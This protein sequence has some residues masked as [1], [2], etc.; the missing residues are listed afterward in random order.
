MFKCL[1]GVCPYGVI[2]S[3]DIDF[4]CLINIIKLNSYQNSK[5]YTVILFYIFNFK[6]IIMKLLEVDKGHLPRKSRYKQ[7]V[8]VLKDHRD[9]HKKEGNKIY[10]RFQDAINILI[11]EGFES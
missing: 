9:F 3:Y 4:K 1:L 6:Y 7:P 2:Y 10:E 11:K 5:S 8:S